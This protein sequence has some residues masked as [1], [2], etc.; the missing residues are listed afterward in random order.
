MKSIQFAIMAVLIFGVAVSPVFS[1]GLAFAQTEGEIPVEEGEIPVEQREDPAEQ[2]ESTAEQQK[3][4]REQKA[5]EKEQ[6]VSEQQQRVSEQQE[7]VSDKERP[8]ISDERRLANFEENRARL[9]DRIGN[10]PEEQR[11]TIQDRLD[12]MQHKR[13]SMHNNTQSHANF[14]GLSDEDRQSK[15]GEI[16]EKRLELRE[17]RMNM[18]PEERQALFDEN[19]ERLMEVRE[20][21]VSPRLQFGFG[22]PTDEVICVEGKELVIRVSNGM[23]TCLSSD[24]V[25]LLMDRGIV[26]YPE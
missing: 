2:T 4:A 8:R 14:M 6:R 10:L 5:S 13:A 3:S 16:R 9:A 12:V 23:P 17:A 19:K 7:R 22:V 20:N 15:L 25:V 21:Y 26:T 11:Q 18:T 24:G 1:N